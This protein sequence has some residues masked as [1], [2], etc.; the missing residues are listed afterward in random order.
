M[1]QEIS[2]DVFGGYCEMGDNINPNLSL[3]KKKTLFL[4]SDE[5]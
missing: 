2:S 3:I 5:T 4:C 1:L